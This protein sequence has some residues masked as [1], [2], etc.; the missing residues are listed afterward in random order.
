ML[1][2]IKLLNSKN[3]DKS[4]MVKFSYEDAR[5]PCGYNVF[6][7]P[8]DF[9]MDSVNSICYMILKNLTSYYSTSPPCPSSSLIQFSNDTEVEGFIQLLKSGF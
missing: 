7:C 2:F 4:N 6:T 9:V 3:P 5:K 1:S 8:Q